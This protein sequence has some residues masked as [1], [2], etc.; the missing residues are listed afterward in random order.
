VAAVRVELRVHG[1]VQGVFYRASAHRQARALGLCGYGE[2]RDD[3][4]VAVVAEG[5][6]SAIDRLVV[7]CRTGPPAARVSHVD[8]TR[9]EASGEFGD[10]E[11][12]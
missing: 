3:G 9:G 7:W 12:R 2:N 1:R 8:V 6:T 5:E 11:V 4:S 10:F